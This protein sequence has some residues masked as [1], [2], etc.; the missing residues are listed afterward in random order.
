MGR[1]VCTCN[2]VGVNEHSKGGG[3]AGAI[4]I[5]YFLFACISPSLHD[6]VATLSLPGVATLSPPPY[7][8]RWY[9]PL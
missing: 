8:T 4:I 5:K 9:S 2:R 3:G 6:G 7:C 1:P